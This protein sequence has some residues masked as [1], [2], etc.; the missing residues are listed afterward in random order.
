MTAVINPLRV[1]MEQVFY[2]GGGRQVVNALI[3]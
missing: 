1:C 2:V 3:Q